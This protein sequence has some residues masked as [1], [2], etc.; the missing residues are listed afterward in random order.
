MNFSL[1]E[2]SLWGCLISG[3]TRTNGEKNLR[4]LP[5]MSNQVSFTFDENEMKLY[6]KELLSISPEA[7]HETQNQVIDV[8]PEEKEEQKTDDEETMPFDEDLKRIKE[9]KSKT[10]RK[11]QIQNEILTDQMRGGLNL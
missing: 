11:R 5:A 1:K 6:L 9:T 4:N 2:T 10:R 3:I 8:E 7:L